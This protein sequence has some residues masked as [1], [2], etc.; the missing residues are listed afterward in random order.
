MSMKKMILALSI[1]VLLAN[2]ITVDAQEEMPVS[3]T[4]TEIEVNQETGEFQVEITICESAAYA[5]MEFGMVCGP[6]CEITSVTYDKEVSTTGPVESNLI[7]FGFFDGEDSFSES[8]TATVHGTC[9][10]GADSEMALKTV[11]KY[12]IGESEYREEEFTV[13]TKINL[14]SETEEM[15]VQEENTPL[16][17]AWK[18]QEISAWVIALGII[19]AVGIV[20]ALIYIGFVRKTKDQKMAE[21]GEK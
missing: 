14:V 18:E 21:R 11:K 1:L 8:F 3:L 4:N 20:G 10:I 2:P 9:R 17:F 6:E 19:G 15:Q 7:W 16:A 5:G 12:T 13:D